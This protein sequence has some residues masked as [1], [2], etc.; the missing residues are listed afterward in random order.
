MP[1]L[2]KQRTPSSPGIVTFTSSEALH[3]AAATS[4]RM[5]T[6]LEQASAR[7]DWIF[8]THVQGDFSSFS[9]PR[10]PWQSFVMWPEPAA[11]FLAGI[12]A[13]ER[14]ALNCVNFMP[15][16]HLEDAVPEAWW[17]VLTLIR[18]SSVKRSSETL[19]MLQA[20]LDRRPQT[21][22]AVVASDPRDQ[23]LGEDAYTRQAI[24]REFFELP[25]RI[26]SSR[27]LDH[28]SFFSSSVMAFGRFP[29]EESLVYRLLAR[30]RF[31]LLASHSEGTPRA[32]AESLLAGRPCI[33]SEHLRSGIRGELNEQNALFVPDDVEAS[34]EAIAAALDGYASFAVD[35]LRARERFGASRN[36][37]ELQA[38]LTAL[39]EA[40]ER[41]VE[42]EWYLDELHL[43]LAGHG[44][45][46]DAQF[47]DSDETFFAWLDAVQRLD[48]YDEDA[49]LGGAGAGGAVTGWR[50]PPV[51]LRRRVSTWLRSVAL[52][53]RAALRKQRERRAYPSPREGGRRA[54]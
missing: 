17:D 10:L 26:F 25:L 44:Q 15:E 30:S 24:E 49:I 54:R 19:R 22:V 40:S 43:R 27:Q 3:G 20:L 2:L 7:G 28:V 46:Y 1:C 8:G 47:M 48:P 38:R 9:W 31:M 42:G 32:V 36:R 52:H 29:L 23:S 39:L 53:V 12:P 6:F 34:A 16:R 5:R 13:D 18:P 11:Q 33:V 35:R 50:Q 41:P 14:L 21:R 51:P 37:P 4:Q 45:K